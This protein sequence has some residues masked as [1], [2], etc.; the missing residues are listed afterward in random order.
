[1]KALALLLIVLSVVAQAAAV[2]VLFDGTFDCASLA[3]TP[4]S[5]GDGTLQKV[6]DACAADPLCAKRAGIEGGGT[7]FHFEQLL[8][9]AQPFGPGAPTVEAGLRHYLCGKTVEDAAYDLYVDRL[10]V[11]SLVVV[12]CPV[13]R[14]YVPSKDRCRPPLVQSQDESWLHALEYSVL[15][16]VII[17][18]LY[19]V[20]R[21]CLK[22]PSFRKDVD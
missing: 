1:M 14:V 4:L 18:L 9:Q 7:L 12:P 22:R 5:E 3:S 15:I 21:N 6:Y 10:T 17:G 16:M 13:D 11:A 20:L 2:D 8:A 19:L